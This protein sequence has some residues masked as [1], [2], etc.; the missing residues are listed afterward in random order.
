MYYLILKR[1]I[2][3]YL[4]IQNMYEFIPYLFSFK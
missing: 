3:R 4:Q 1:V 2:H